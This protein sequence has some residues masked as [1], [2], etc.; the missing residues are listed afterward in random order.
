[1]ISTTRFQRF[2]RREIVKPAPKC[3]NVT[4]GANMEH[5][6]SV[7]I[8]RKSWTNV[9]VEPQRPSVLQRHHLLRWRRR[10][11]HNRSE[12]KNAKLI[13]MANQNQNC[14]RGGKLSK[15]FFNFCS[16]GKIFRITRNKRR[17]AKLTQGYSLFNAKRKQTQESKLKITPKTAFRSFAKHATETRKNLFGFLTDYGKSLKEVI[18]TTIKNPISIGIDS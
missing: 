8:R 18:V 9:T 6:G 7:F 2:S 11:C 13:Q 3:L 1:M 10:W 15:L 16:I 5:S 12:R 17:P 14:Y 4:Y